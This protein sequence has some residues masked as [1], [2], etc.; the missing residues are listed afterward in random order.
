MTVAEQLGT[1]LLPERL[2]TE[3]FVLRRHRRDD[4][5]AMARLLDNWNIV[6]WLAEVP[7]PYRREDATEWIVETVHRWAE[8]TDH[9]FVI[10]LRDGDRPIGHMGLRPEDSTA[11]F[12]YWIGQPFWGTGCA[13]EAGRAV[14]DFGFAHLELE[15]IWATCLPDNHRSLSVLRRL[16]FRQVGRRFQKFLIRSER[17]EVPL[18]AVERPGDRSLSGRKRRG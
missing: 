14:L 16:G 6:R 11:E 3:R 8:G 7:F 17:I 15:R 12:G 13:V 18:L 10:T 1:E 4:A 9:Q 5:A 2:E